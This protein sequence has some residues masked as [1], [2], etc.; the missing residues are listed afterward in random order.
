MSIWHDLAD[1]LVELS[2][3]LDAQAQGFA[4]VEADIDCPLEIR[5]VEAQGRPRFLAIAPHSRWK[6]GFLPPVH[7][8]RLR[9]AADE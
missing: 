3:C 7:R 2:G 8:C 1:T 9:L 4:I 5:V 6:A